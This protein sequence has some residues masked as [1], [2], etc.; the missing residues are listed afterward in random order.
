[1]SRHVARFS[2]ENS[3]AVLSIRWVDE[4]TGHASFTDRQISSAFFSRTD[5]LC[6]VYDCECDCV[7][8]GL[9]AGWVLWRPL[10]LLPRGHV[11]R[12]ERIP[13][14]KRY[15]LAPMG[16]EI[17][18]RK[19]QPRQSEKPTCGQYHNLTT[20]AHTPSRLLLPHERGF[21]SQCI[22]WFIPKSRIC[23]LYLTSWNNAWE[24]ARSFKKYSHVTCHMTHTQ[25]KNYVVL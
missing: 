12:G 21:T 4:Y 15:T 9:C 13:V 17:S 14:H 3:T 5:R 1:M 6:T 24:V 22:T 25:K 2:L 10:T 20:C 18:F 16:Q 23:S 19:L 7:C 8:N 11:L